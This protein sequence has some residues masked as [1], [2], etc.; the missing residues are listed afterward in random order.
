MEHMSETIGFQPTLLQ[1][2]GDCASI[3]KLIAGLADAGLQGLNLGKW[4]A[5]PGQAPLGQHPNEAWGL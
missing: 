3:V 4:G 5:S 2:A 1:N